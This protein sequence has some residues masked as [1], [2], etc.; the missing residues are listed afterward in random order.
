MCLNGFPEL[1]DECT[2]KLRSEYPDDWEVIRGLDTRAHALQRTL[3][4][5]FQTASAAHQDGSEVI[6]AYLND[7]DVPCYLHL[8]PHIKSD[9]PLVVSAAFVEQL[10]FPESGTYLKAEAVLDYF[11]FRYSISGKYMQLP[12]LYLQLLKAGAPALP[13][14]FLAIQEESFNRL[15]LLYTY[16]VYISAEDDSSQK[17]LL[18]ILYVVYKPDWSIINPFTFPD[19]QVMRHLIKLLERDTS[20]DKKEFIEHLFGY[21]KDN[22]NAL[23]SKVPALNIPSRSTSQPS[24]GLEK[25]RFNR[26]FKLDRTGRFD[27]LDVSLIVETLAQIND[28]TILKQMQ[29]A[30]SQREKDIKK[31]TEESERDR[32]RGISRTQRVLGKHYSFSD[33][34]VQGF[35]AALT[36]LHAVHQEVKKFIPLCKTHGDIG[37]LY[38]IWK[39]N[40]EIDRYIENQLSEIYPEIKSCRTQKG[41]PVKPGFH[42]TTDRRGHLAVAVRY[43]SQPD[44]RKPLGPSDLLLAGYS[45]PSLPNE[46]TLT[47]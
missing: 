13:D 33:G 31:S 29:Q 21:H 14:M 44:Q 38:R 18:G 37:F 19:P 36:H 30:L 20:S 6:A 22:Y 10:G 1:R 27:N 12:E 35:E 42:E 23:S 25:H 15:I 47:M 45:P 9:D 28:L 2:K 34:E 3:S 32:Y 8:A 40:L 26:D 16:P 4:G 11:R 43:G 24:F 7:V 5:L 39:G 17:T 46:V 41:H